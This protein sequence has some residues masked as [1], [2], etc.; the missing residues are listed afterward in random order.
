MSTWVLIYYIISSALK[1][2]LYATVVPYNYNPVDSEMLD[3]SEENFKVMIN[4]VEIILIRYSL[5]L[6]NPFSDKETALKVLTVALAWTLGNSICSNLLYFLM[7]ATGEEFNWE[8]IITAIESNFDLIERLATVALVECIDQEHKSLKYKASVGSILIL[9]YAFLGLGFKF[10]SQLQTDDK[11]VQLYYKAIAT[12]VLGL[13]SR[14]IFKRA[15]KNQE[16]L[17]GE[18]DDIYKRHEETN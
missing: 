1:M 5:R 14:V 12:I 18:L 17:Q 2:I 9:K 10:I 15:F 16:D 4:L 13:I 11:W 6:K 7:N 8:Y 3:T